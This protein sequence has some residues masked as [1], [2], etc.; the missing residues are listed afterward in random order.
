MVEFRI[1]VP[2]HCARGRAPVPLFRQGNQIQHRLLRDFSVIL[3]GVIRRDASI[4]RPL[5]AAHET[6]HPAG[7]LHQCLFAFQANL[8]NV[9]ESGLTGASRLARNVGLKRDGSSERSTIRS[10]VSVENGKAANVVWMRSTFLRP[11]CS[12]LS[13]AKRT[14]SATAST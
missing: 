12:S 2:E 7:A 1:R 14:M 4:N 9:H 13:L 8:V 3:G 11:S 10:K 6:L 5:S